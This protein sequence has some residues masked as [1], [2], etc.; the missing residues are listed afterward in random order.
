MKKRTE[1]KDNK[2]GFRS[3]KG[4]Y[5]PKDG[6]ERRSSDRGGKFS[7]RREDDKGSSFRSDSRG[8]FRGERRNSSFRS[9][10]GSYRP[11]DGEERRSSDR[12]VK[13]SRRREDDKGS[14][15]RSDSRGG[16]RGE[17]RNSGFRSDKGSYRPKDGE[18]RR[19]SDRGGKFSRRR[20]DDKGSSF[21]SDSRGGFR[22]ERRNSGFR[23]DKGSYRPKDGEERRSSDRGGKFSRRREDDKGSSFR[24][25]SRGGFRGERRNSGFRSDKGSY[26]PK[27]GEERRSSDR[28]GKFS[29]RRE[30]DKGSSFRSDSRG[31]FRGERR[32]SGFRSDKGSYRPKDGEKDGMRIAKKIASLGYCSRRD[33]ESLIEKGKVKINGEVVKEFYTQVGLKEKIEV[34]G[35]ELPNKMPPRE[36]YLFHKPVGCVTTNYDP[37]GRKTV[38]DYISEKFGRLITVG[39]LD[40]NTDGLLL[41]TN[42]GHFARKMELPANSIEREY[43]VKVYGDISQADLD[44]LKDGVVI[45]EMKYGEIDAKIVK[46]NDNKSDIKICIKE[47]KN[48]EIRNIMKYL[49]L[50][51]TKLTRIRYGRYRLDGIP[52]GCIMKYKEK[53][54]KG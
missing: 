41:L 37:E 12:G 23:S 38:F 31:G 44:K 21:R 54:L 19:S 14:S 1:N 51:I 16:F 47:G 33:A 39:R 36:I 26:R 50:G 35:K 52:V 29:R 28:G 9:D 11:K 18:E 34:E 6:E 30:D 3:D 7:R 49:N 8:G 24:S 20:E 46:K 43:L 22:G 25:D 4:S 45:D 15:F 32:N 17:R 53:G 2:K 27:D 10:K 5:R 40:F 42:D 13:F 48:R